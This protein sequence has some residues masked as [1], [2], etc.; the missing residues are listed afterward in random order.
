V[1]QHILDADIDPARSRPGGSGQ[2]APP[3]TVCGGESDD[4][5]P[6][7]GR[8]CG[9]HDP[10][11]LPGG[12]WYYE[13]ASRW[14]HRL[15]LADCVRMRDESIAQEAQRTPSPAPIVDAEMSEAPIRR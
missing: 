12:E 11:Y 6:T 7:L 15:T 9:A 8:L 4:M 1:I 5:H 3:C 2:I 13:P 10:R 14:S